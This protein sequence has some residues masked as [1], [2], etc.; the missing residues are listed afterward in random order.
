MPTD[1]NQSTRLFGRKLIYKYPMLRKIYHPKITYSRILF[2]FLSCLLKGLLGGYCNT[3]LSGTFGMAYIR[4]A[5][6]RQMRR[7]DEKPIVLLNVE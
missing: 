6:C 5:Y 1:R 4:T 2:V 3:E 7:S